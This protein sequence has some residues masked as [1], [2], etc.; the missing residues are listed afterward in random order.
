MCRGRLLS[1][2]GGGVQSGKREFGLCEACVLPWVSCTPAPTA[3]L[4]TR[5]SPSPG[6][7]QWPR[8]GA[9]SALSPSYDAGLHGLVSVPSLLARAPRALLSH[10]T[11]TWSHP[12]REV[13][14]V[15]VSGWLL[16]R[17]SRAE[18]GRVVFKAGRDERLLGWGSGRR[19]PAWCV[20]SPGSPHQ[21]CRN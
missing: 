18:P 9:P 13:H 2:G 7:S 15:P 11:T 10:T 16:S 6:T 12:G 17:G 3:C 5:A 8:A 21:P 20:P 14:S 19:A 1:D 4:P